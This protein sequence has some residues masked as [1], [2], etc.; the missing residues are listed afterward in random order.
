MKSVRLWSLVIMKISCRTPSSAKL[1]LNMAPAS[2]A[3]QNEHRW[4]QQDQTHCICARG[5]ASTAML[6]CWYHSQTLPDRT[7]GPACS[8]GV[9]FQ[10]FLLL[11][12]VYIPAGS[13]PSRGRMQ[14]K[15]HCLCSVPPPTNIWH[16][17]GSRLK[18]TWRATLEEKWEH[19]QKETCG[20]I[21]GSDR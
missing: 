3:G 19:H 16:V 14:N 6:V 21:K 4:K 8:L 10:T 18:R 13:D 17:G 5:F 7:K 15:S 9:P 12:S 2:Q 20:G 11:I 1:A